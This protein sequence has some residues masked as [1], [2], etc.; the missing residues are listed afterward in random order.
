MH[1]QDIRVVDDVALV[2]WV[3][4]WRI[5]FQI[6]LGEPPLGLG[7]HVVLVGGVVQL[8]LEQDAVEFQPWHL[9]GRDFVDI[10]PPGKAGRSTGEAG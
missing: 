6:N 9:L 7:E 10:A 8:V 3:R 2:G 5:V 1:D 4:A